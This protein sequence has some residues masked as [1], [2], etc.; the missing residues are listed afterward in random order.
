M[1]HYFDN[2]ELNGHKLT[3]EAENIEDDIANFTPQLVRLKQ[4]QIPAVLQ[5]DQIK[6]IASQS[7]QKL[8][9]HRANLNLAADCGNFLNLAA[10]CGSLAHL[11]LEMIANEGLEHWPASRIDTASQAM[12]FWLMQ[13]G[14]AKIEVEKYVVQIISALKQTIASPQG[15][16]LLARRASM[17]VELSIS[18]AEEEQRIDLTF[19]ENGTRWIIDY[20]LG[21]EVTEASVNETAQAHKAQ[22]ARYAALFVNENCQIKTAV[23]FIKLGKLV[24]I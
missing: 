5:T 20:K 6:I 24:E 4:L 17:Q 18:T 11:Y 1:S 12:L 14:Y 7:K 22:L 21:L 23:F 3:A 19:V 13:C 10:D 8:A 9:P 15:S 2:I 16:W